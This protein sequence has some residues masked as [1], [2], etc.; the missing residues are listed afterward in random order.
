MVLPEPFTTAR[1]FIASFD[2]T[3]IASGTGFVTFYLCA[4]AGGHILSPDIIYSDLI[5]SL[6]KLSGGGNVQDIDY[7]VTFNLPRTISGTAVINIPHALKNGGSG[8]ETSQ[9]TIKLIHYDGSTETVMATTTGTAI[10]DDPGVGGTSFR[11]DCTQ[12]AITTPQHFASG[13]ILRVN[14]VQACTGN[15]ATDCVIGQDPKGRNGAE[16]EVWVWENEPSQAS[17][18]IPFLII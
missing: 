10:S 17:I 8:T 16:Q 15:T 9:L 5:S 14:V 4:T 6:V 18:Q 2:A 12:L 7:D 11:M 13:D 1:E 3:D